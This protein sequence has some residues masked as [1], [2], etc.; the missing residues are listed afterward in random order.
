MELR[1]D[2]ATT[3]RPVRRATASGTCPHMRALSTDEATRPSGAVATLAA[4]AHTGQAGVAHHPCDA[5]APAGDP[6]PERELGVGDRPRR[7]RTG[8]RLVVA[9]PGNVQHL[10]GHRDGVP[11]L[12]QLTDQRGRHRG[13]STFSWAKHAEARLRISISI[14]W[15]RFSHRSRTSSSRSPVLRPSLRPAS[16]SARVQTSRT[17]LQGAVS[18][19][20][21][22]PDNRGRLRPLDTFRTRSRLIPRA[23]D[24]PV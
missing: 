10:A 1:A 8:G 6:E 9:R 2:R 13:G 7:R 5:F 3:G 12:G 15:R 22:C 4:V 23:G 19:Q 18:P 21:R 11:V 16:M 14:A 24:R 17:P 20:L